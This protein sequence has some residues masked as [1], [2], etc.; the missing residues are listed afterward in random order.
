MEENESRPPLFG[1]IVLF[2][3]AA[4]ITVGV[5][6]LTYGLYSLMRNGTWPAYPFSKML[7]EIGFPLPHLTWPSGQRA[8]DWVLSS[9]ACT[10]LLAIGAVI[11]GTGAWLIA[12]HNRRLRVAAEAA[13]AAA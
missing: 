11:A 5:V 1:L 2:I 10:V 4:F 6:F 7:T 8:I 12:R 13:E 3:G 9:S